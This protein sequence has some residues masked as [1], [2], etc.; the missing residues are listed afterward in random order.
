MLIDALDEAADPPG[1]ISGLLRPLIQERRGALRLLL[2]TRPHLLTARLLGKPEAAATCRSIWTPSNTPTRPASAPT[3]GGSCSPRTPLDSAYKPSGLYRTAPAAALDAV[4]EAIGEA[5]GASFL[6]ARITAATEA[7]TARLPDPTDP[8]LAAGPAAARR[9]RDAPGPAVAARRGR[10]QSCEAAAPSGL[11]PGQ[12]PALGRHLAPSGG[13]AVTRPRYGNNDLIWLRKTAGS[14]AVEGLA[15]GRSVYRLYHQALAEHLLER[16]DQ[17]ADQQA[18][19]SALTSLVPP[20]EGGT[21]DWHG[22]HPYI[23]AH[24][25]T[26]AAQAGRV[27]HLLADPAYL[28]AASQP[29]LLAALG[30]AGTNP[31]RPPPTHTAAPPTICAWRPQSSTPPT[32][33]WLRAVQGPPS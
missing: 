8:A 28:L 18:I 19:T 26:H 31:H 6:V 21:R 32:C 9:A 17:R 1:L 27:D 3:S 4:T 33:N 11:R 23:R 16:R 14:Y 5:A 12:R 22:A 20:G 15:D 25:A 24:L 30:A 13:R 7:T 2:G 10:G 29:Q